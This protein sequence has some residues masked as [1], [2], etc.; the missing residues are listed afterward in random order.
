MTTAA[1]ATAPPAGPATPSESPG[2]SVRWRPYA[3]GAIL[4]VATGLYGWDIWNAGWGNEFYSA[5]VKSMSQGL[6]NFVFGSYDPAGVVTV[7]KPPMGLWPQ[8]VSVW[9]FGWHAWALALPQALEG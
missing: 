9:I 1:E 4:V 8:V 5:A 2:R 7:D 3:L 6:T